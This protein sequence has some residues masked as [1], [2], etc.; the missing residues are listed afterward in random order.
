MY[1]DLKSWGPVTVLLVAVTVVASI[2]G[3]AVVV[4]H[5]ETLSFQQLLNDLEEFAKALGILAVGRGLHMGLTNNALGSVVGDA[6]FAGKA[7]EDPPVVTPPT[8]PAA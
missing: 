3:A 5:P 8:T 6:Q 7:T 2:A 1:L 4:I